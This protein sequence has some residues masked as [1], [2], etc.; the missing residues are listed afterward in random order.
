MNSTEN[1]E[2][3]FPERSKLA[4]E[5]TEIIFRYF[6]KVHGDMF[7]VVGDQISGGRQD[8]LTR[9]PFPILGDLCCS[10]SDSGP[11][12]LTAADH[13]CFVRLGQTSPT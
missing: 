12:I 2:T 6:R 1:I 4:L 11:R 9:L 7:I 3:C 5:L 8:V 10:V 13:V